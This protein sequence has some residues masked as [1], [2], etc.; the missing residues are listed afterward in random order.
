MTIRTRK[1]GALAMLATAAVVAMLAVLGTLVMAGA[2][3]AGGEPPPTGTTCVGLDL[4]LPGN[5]NKVT[6]C[7]ATGSAGNPFIINEVSQSAAAS[8]LLNPDHHGDCG[9]FGDGTLVCVQ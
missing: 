5:L 3:F 6:L 1:K 9:R 8:H 4:P 7:H 2:A